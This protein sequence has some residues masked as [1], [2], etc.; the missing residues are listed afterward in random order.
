MQNEEATLMKSNFDFLKSEFPVLATFGGQAEKYC[1]SDSN[2]CLMKLGMIG[3]SIVNL[4]FTYDRIQFPY[5]NTAVARID[6]LQREGLITRDLTDI[7]HSLRKARNKAVHE[8]Y[9]SLSECKILLEMAYSLC[10]WFMQTYG[11]WN[12][13]HHDFVMPKLENKKLTVTQEEKA[14]EEKQ[15]EELTKQAEKKASEADVISKLERQKQAGKMASP[16]TKIRS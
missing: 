9:E 1:F 13:Q 8:N 7:L 4:M 14:A 2:S 6:T 15:A 11:D 5:D 16:T 12:Y 3:E 10:E